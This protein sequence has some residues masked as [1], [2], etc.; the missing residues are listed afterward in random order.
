MISSGFFQLSTTKKAQVC[1]ATEETRKG[2]KRTLSVMFELTEMPIGGSSIN[3]A[4]Q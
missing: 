4:I 3:L 1:L 2:P